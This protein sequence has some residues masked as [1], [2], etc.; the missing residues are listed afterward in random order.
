[1]GPATSLMHPGS[2]SEDPDPSDYFSGLL[3]CM[4]PCSEVS[5]YPIVAML[6]RPQNCILQGHKAA[7]ITE[8]A[9]CRSKAKNAQE[10]HEAIRPTKPGRLPD[11]AQLPKGSQLAR[12]YSLIWAR[13]LA[14]QMRSASLLQVP[15]LLLTL[16]QWHSLPL[17]WVRY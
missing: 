9:L 10:A 11:Q 16:W 5:G 15:A 2:T 3:I 8:P 6:S 7:Y 1:M 14:S 4:C 13:A 17:A 12:L